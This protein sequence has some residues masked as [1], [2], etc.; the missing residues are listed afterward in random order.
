MLLNI[1]QDEATKAI[2]Q[3]VVIVCNKNRDTNHLP[4]VELINVIVY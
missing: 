2:L 1:T 3:S 4:K